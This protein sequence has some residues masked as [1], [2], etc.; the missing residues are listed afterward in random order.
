MSSLDLKS[1]ARLALT[2]LSDVGQYSEEMFRA[3]VDSAIQSVVEVPTGEYTNVPSD[4][5]VVFSSLVYLVV[6]ASKINAESLELRYAKQTSHNNVSNFLEDFLTR[7]DR[8]QYICSKYTAN[9]QSIRE[10]VLSQK[11]FAF[12]K[13]V[14]IDWRL[15]YVVKSSAVQKT[16]EPVYTLNFR[17]SNGESMKLAC[18]VD[19]LQDL[20]AKFRDAVKQ[21]ERTQEQL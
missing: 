9:R 1:E 17:F 2:Q 4:Q 21:I 13:L 16:N 5:K 10:K 6:E 15:D 8:V 7:N 14:D 11:T 3:L 20:H 19:Q 12:P 18:T